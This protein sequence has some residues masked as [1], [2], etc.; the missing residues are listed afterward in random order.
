[1]GVGTYRLDGPHGR[2]DLKDPLQVSDGANHKVKSEEDQGSNARI[3][4]IHLARV[5][6]FIEQDSNIQNALQRRITNFNQCDT[7]D[8]W[9]CHSLVL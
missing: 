3:G 8:K 1:L 4:A 6:K 2:P 9:G 5:C 7:S